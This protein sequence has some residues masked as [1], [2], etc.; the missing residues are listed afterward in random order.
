MFKV[1]I[2]SFL[3]SYAYPGTPYLTGVRVC[4]LPY[5]CCEHEVDCYCC[6]EVN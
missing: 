5:S 2:D 6:D 1:E 4:D 3:S